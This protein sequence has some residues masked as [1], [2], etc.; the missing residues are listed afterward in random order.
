MPQPLAF[1]L[2]PTSL[3]NMVGQE[4]IRQTIKSFLEKGQVPSMIFRG[5]PGCGKTTLAHVLS[6]E[7]QADF[8]ELSGVKSKKEDLTAI[9][10]HAEKNKAYG[11]R[12]VLFLDEIHRRNKAQQDALLPFVESGLITLIGATTENP[13]FTINNALLSRA[14]V[15]VFEPLKEEDIVQFFENNYSRIVSF[16]MQ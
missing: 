8:F 11:K 10:E 2:R 16:R 6:S 4:T 1:A 13:S 5:P 12:T 14:K 3:E 15:L 9:I 7:L